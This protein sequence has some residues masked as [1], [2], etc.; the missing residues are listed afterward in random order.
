M[1]SKVLQYTYLHTQIAKSLVCPITSPCK[2]GVCFT[3]MNVINHDS[4]QKIYEESRSLSPPFLSH[5]T[6]FQKKARKELLELRLVGTF[7]SEDV[8]YVSLNMS[9]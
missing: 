6:S 1:R 9:S 7:T 2:L 4:G 8:L 3:F 5:A